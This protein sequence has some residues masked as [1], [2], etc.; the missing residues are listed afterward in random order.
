MTTVEKEKASVEGPQRFLNREL[1]SLDFNE[2]VLE[3]AADPRLPLLE[4]LTFCSRFSQHLDEFFAVRV[5]GLMGQDAS[6]LTV[7]SLDGRTPQQTL[8]EIRTRVLA[9]TAEQSELWRQELLP[10]LEK[11]GIRIGRIADCTEKELDELAARFDR[12]IYPVLTPLAV[13]PGKPCLHHEGEFSLD[14][15]RDEAIRWYQPAIGKEHVVEQDAG[16]R[17]VDIE[18]A[19]HRLR[20]QADLVAL[21]G[22][23]LGDLHLDPCLLDRIG[24][25]NGNAGVL[26][27]DLP[28]LRAGFFR[29]VEPFGGGADI[30]LGK[31]HG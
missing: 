22:A 11:E 5:S 4:R 28:D 23:V 25:R 24:V 3:L 13:G 20:R 19:L 9:M 31:G 15:G 17:L 12:E 8:S 7:H 30:V 6:G 27:R 14:A 10:A 18:C 26:Q 21:D 1:S 29:V 2:R 16:I